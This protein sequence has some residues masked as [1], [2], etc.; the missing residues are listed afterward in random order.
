MLEDPDYFGMP[1]RKPPHN[2]MSNDCYRGCRKILG[3][4]NDSSKPDEPLR[5]T[6]ECVEKASFEKIWMN[7]VLSR[8][9]EYP[10]RLVRVEFVRKGIDQTGQ[11]MA[12]PLEVTPENYYDTTYP[13]DYFCSNF[14][15]VTKTE[16]EATLESAMS[17]LWDLQKKADL[18]GLVNWHHLGKSCLPAHWFS[19]T[20]KGA[21]K[22]KTYDGGCEIC[23]WTTG[24]DLP[25]PQPQALNFEYLRQRH[26]K[27][28]TAIDFEQALR[29]VDDQPATTVAQHGRVL[30]RANSEE[31][32]AVL[33]RVKRP[34]AITNS[35]MQVLEED[36]DVPEIAVADALETKIRYKIKYLEEDEE[37]NGFWET[38]AE[39]EIDS[40]A[41]TVVDL[42]RTGTPR[43]RRT[44]LLA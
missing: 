19:R 38:D 6:V 11:Y 23:T 25:M 29:D 7:T 31:A 34:E 3:S 39:V 9:V 1:L 22:K 43:V 16:L 44:C 35:D 18:H 26:A 42:T 40:D 20:K 4:F 8:S 21:P 30:K 27:Q 41:E 10:D 17:E 2:A 13:L 37:Y 24:C 15:P 36:D 12:V 28:E 33:K 5:S 32:I 14:D